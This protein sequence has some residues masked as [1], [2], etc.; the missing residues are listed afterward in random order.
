MSREYGMLIICDRCHKRK[1]LEAAGEDEYDGGWSVVKKTVPI[2]DDWGTFVEVGDRRVDL[3]PKCAAAFD[4]I[5]HRFMND[6]EAFMTEV[7]DANES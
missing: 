3:C 2:P 5:S 6:C 4:K 1:F 7:G